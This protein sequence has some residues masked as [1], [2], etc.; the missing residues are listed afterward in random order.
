MNKTL[1]EMMPTR[2]R[3]KLGAKS[4]VCLLNGKNV[5][6]ALQAEKLIVMACNTRIKQVIPGIMQAAEELDAVVA[7]ELTK[8]EGGLDG[9]YTGQT[10]EIFFN[11]VVDYAERVKFSKP[12]II[13]GDH[14]TVRNTSPEELAEAEKLLRAQI[15]AGFSSFAIDASFNPLQ[16]NI[17]IVNL[18]AR[19]IKAE[20]LGL[21]VELGEIK[22]VGSE[23]K[24]TSVSETE[25]FLQGLAAS[26]VHPLLVAIDNGSKSGNYLDGQKINIDLVRTEE[27][28]RITSAF[29]VTGLVQHGITGTPLH[30]V[31]K[32]A[33][34]GIRKGNIGTLWQNV[35]HAGLPL[36]L[37][38]SMR[39]W[40][41][42]NKRDIKYATTV[43]KAEIDAIPEENA[44]QI[45]EMAY[46]E[47]RDFIT[48]FRAKGSAGKLAGLLE[49]AGCA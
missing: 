30:I 20:G 22:P 23:S 21:E 10:P 44:R 12:F 11:T 1:R 32:L 39:R 37:M 18:L 7:F 15:S 3:K 48:A 34:F 14:I 8:S 45:H 4:Q 33:D 9:G 16:D 28:F 35:A 13:H 40:A 29:G 42:E 26:D 46:R 17:R 49:V 31:G 36:D 43:F 24:L 19:H 25:E 6:C 27:I 41:R 38:E 5:F 2:V 47:A